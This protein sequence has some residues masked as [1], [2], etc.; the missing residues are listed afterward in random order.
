MTGERETP[1]Y[2]CLR[3]SQGL[4]RIHE[5]DISA[6]SQQAERHSWVPEAHEYCGWP[7]GPE[8]APGQGPVPAH[9][10]VVALV[11]KRRTETRVGQLRR[12]GIRVTSGPWTAFGQAAPHGGGRLI[13]ALGRAAGR[14]TARSRVRR[15][16][17]EVFLERFGGPPKVD[18]LLLARS[19]VGEEPRAQVRGRLG[20]LLTR[21]SV[22]LARRQAGGGS[23]A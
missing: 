15:I 13:V 4:W 22:V 16:A 23:H 2:Y 18:L 21:L 9:G 10:V 1:Y 14:A 19:D 3:L 8:A 6:E 12:H 7:Q 17:R 11:G 20:E 5:A